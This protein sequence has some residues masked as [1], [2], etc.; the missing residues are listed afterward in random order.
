[1][2]DSAKTPEGK[3]KE[4]DRLEKALALI[5][6]NVSDYHL[7]AVEEPESAAMSM[8]AWCFE[9]KGVLCCACIA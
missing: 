8:Y 2:T 9:T 1:M 3:G 6:M 7:T 4:E 5:A